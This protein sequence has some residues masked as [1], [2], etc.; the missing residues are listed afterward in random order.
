MDLCNRC[1][2]KQ[3][4]SLGVSRVSL[5]VAAYFVKAPVCGITCLGFES[6]HCYWPPL[7]PGC[8]STQ[9]STHAGLL[10]LIVS[11]PVG[12]CVSSL[13]EYSCR[14]SH[15]WF[16]I[17]EVLSCTTSNICFQVHDSVMQNRADRSRDFME[18]AYLDFRGI[19]HNVPLG[20]MWEI[21]KEKFNHSDRRLAPLTTRT[22]RDSN[23]YRWDVACRKAT[24]SSWAI[25]TPWSNW[26]HAHQLSGDTDVGG[27]ANRSEDSNNI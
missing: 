7:F 21:E 16:P 23:S 22:H 2:Q 3:G 27:S 26:K 4:E 14:C 25:S 9:V 15:F 1:E 13:C 12:S 8:V 5:D 17:S 24:L 6:R 11:T 18:K 19:L 10:V 20:E